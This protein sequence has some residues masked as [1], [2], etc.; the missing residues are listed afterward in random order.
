MPIIRFLGGPCHN[1]LRDV[2]RWHQEIYI[3]NMPE[4]LPITYF[5][6][7]AVEP[8][9]FVYATEDYDGLLSV[10][11]WNKLISLPGWKESAISGNASPVQELVKLADYLRKEFPV[12]VSKRYRNSETPI[13]TAIILLTEM[14]QVI[15]ERVLE[16][17][18]HDW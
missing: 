1:E 13:D 3:N 12:A 15:I 4:K 7:S 8:G 14:K 2:Q 17:H 10:H 5:L 9:L 6:K 18:P 16:G 11:G